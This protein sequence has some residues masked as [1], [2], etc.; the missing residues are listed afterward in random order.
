MTNEITT[1]GSELQL[2]ATTSRRINSSLES[3]FSHPISTSSHPNDEYESLM[4]KL[5]SMSSTRDVSKYMI[6]LIGL[7][8]AGK[9]TVSGHLIK[10]LKETNT[11]LNIRCQMFNAGD[12]RRKEKTLQI[13]QDE[14]EDIFDPKNSD[15]REEFAK[16]AFNSALDALNNDKCDISIFDATNSTKQ[17]RKYLFNELRSF[18]HSLNS[19]FVISP[20]V[21]H[22]TCSDKKFVRYNV[23]HKAFNADYF[24]KQYESSIKDFARRLTHYYT[25]FVPYTE[26][27]FDHMHSN[28]LYDN[29]HGIFYFHIANAGSTATTNII[30]YSNMASYDTVKL[31][32]ALDH[33]TTNY[34]AMFGKQYI[35]KVKSFTQFSKVISSNHYNFSNA[36]KELSR[37]KLLRS[38]IDDNYFKKLPRF[39]E[40]NRILEE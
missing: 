22:I 4:H 17:R 20:I 29:H 32:T 30:K 26:D 1:V 38:V 10:F 37:L 8:A 14:T 35:S 40:I 13:A 21:M 16:V 36:L 7:P 18:N 31:I 19:K 27:E 6:I 39:Y 24:D 25:Q 11:T 34:A 2:S 15:R 9:S 12:V 3:L 5:T 28:C 33:F 23:H